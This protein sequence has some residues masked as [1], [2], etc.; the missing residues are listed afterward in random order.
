MDQNVTICDAFLNKDDI[1]CSDNLWI[2][3]NKMY[4][5]QVF[6]EFNDLE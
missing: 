3:L 2:I 4:L 6:N 5:K 1:R